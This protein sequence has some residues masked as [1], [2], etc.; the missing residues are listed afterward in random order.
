MIEPAQPPLW[1]FW[2]GVFHKEERSKTR[3]K[4][5]IFEKRARMASVLR[6][7]TI[8]TVAAVGSSIPSDWQAL[9]DAGNMLFSA[10]IP[11]DGFSPVWMYLPI[12]IQSFFV[13]CRL[14]FS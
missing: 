2:S 11:D 12:D 4:I 6:F 8:V 1:I 10:G 3:L 9:V 14:L 5:R 7:L 13:L